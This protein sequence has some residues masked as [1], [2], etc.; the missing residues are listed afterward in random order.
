MAE[1]GTATLSHFDRIKYISLLLFG[2]PQYLVNNTVLHRLRSAHK[3]VPLSIVLDTLKGLS[4]VILDD[5][6]EHIPRM[7]NF[8]CL[9]INIR[10][11]ASNSSLNERLMYMYAGMRQ[12]TAQPTITS[13]KQDGPKTGSIADT[14]CPNWA[15]QMA[16]RIIDCQPR[17]HRTARRTDVQV[18]LSLATL[19]GQKQQLC[20]HKVAHRLLNR[21]V[22]HDYTLLQET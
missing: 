13:H 4:C 1:C 9:N 22:D 16:H 21:A 12:C 15:R 2:Q 5:L 3:E 18:N 10:C 8:T 11:L 6:I 14:G 7:Q 20:H 17:V 19:S